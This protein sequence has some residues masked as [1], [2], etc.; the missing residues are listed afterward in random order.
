[1]NK[2]SWIGFSIILVVYTALLLTFFKDG[3]TPLIA[4]KTNDPQLNRFIE[5]YNVLKENWI[6]FTDSEEVLNAATQAMAQSNTDN[7]VY[8]M[9]IPPSESEA[10]FNGMES[11]YVGIGVNFFI[12]GNYPIITNVFDNSPALAADMRVGDIMTKVDGVSIEDFDSEKIREKVLGEAG[13]KVVI[14]VLRDGKEIELNIERARIDSSV[15]FH[16]EDNKIGYLKINQFSTTTAQESEV[17]LKDFIANN[18]EDIVIDLRGNPGGLLTSVQETADLFMG[19]NEIV[20]QAQYNDGNIERFTTTN[21]KKYDFKIKV[22]IDGNSASA[23]EVLAAAL[24][25]N[26]D[27]E[28]YGET[29]FGKGIMQA[30]HQ[31]DD[32]GV[33]KFTNAVWLTP[34]GNNINGEG[35][36]PTVEVEQSAIF[37]ALNS[38]F[39]TAEDVKYDSVSEALVSYQ[40]ALKALGYD[41]DRI[42]GYYSSKTQSAL[43]KFKKDNGISQEKDLSIRVQQKIIERLFIE[44]QKPE[45]DYV[46]NKVIK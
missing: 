29:T 19:R 8:T 9:Y 17:A 11:S 43:D 22:L 18:V 35:V 5:N 45:H 37:K 30:H 27:V 23:A 2:K 24:K 38:R 28:V 41:I 1:M 26:L 42:D 40:V 20:L 33:M 12:S 31:Y 34:K 36:K 6:Y 16:I 14:S 4:N 39:S 10:Y 44:S 46:L 13:T 15:S 25:E 21:R 3:S 7:D 32:G